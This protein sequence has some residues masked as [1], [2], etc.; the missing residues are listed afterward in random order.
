MTRP[1]AA[2][3][4]LLALILALS[5]CGKSPQTTVMTVTRA[6]GTPSGRS[7]EGSGT[8]PGGGSHGSGSGLKATRGDRAFAHAVNLTVADVPGFRV[9]HRRS[10]EVVG[11][12]S[13]KHELMQCTAAGGEVS[14][15][16]E[17]GSRDFERSA[18]IASQSVSSAV[19]IAKSPALAAKQLTAIHDGRLP[20][21][22]AR[23]F[24]H[25]LRRQHAQGTTVSP[26]STK[27]G[28]PPAPGTAGSFGLRF[29][30]TITIHRV[31][32]PLYVDIL[33][34]VEGTT[35]VSL[36]STGLPAPLPATTEERLFSL[37]VSRALGHAA[38]LG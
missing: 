14:G 7:S 31:P 29:T 32:I 22:L 26:I 6:T 30:A 8:S 13:L 17:A 19:T 24:N 23:Y 11:E 16:L 9:S 37:L 28:S 3:A 36:F 10:K 34:F 21:C 18:G 33:G 2:L 27:Q 15:V 25:L 38:A 35:K 20:A 1:L 12:V 5:A 4:V